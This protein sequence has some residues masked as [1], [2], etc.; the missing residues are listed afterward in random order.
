[1]NQ[2]LEFWTGEGGD[3]YTRRN[4]VLAT[5]LLRR[6][7][8]W[9]AI[10]DELSLEAAHIL[11]VGPGPGANL[12]VLHDLM[13]D[14]YLYGVEPNEAAR[15]LLAESC[16]FTKIQ[17]GHAANILAEDASFDLVFTAGVLIHIH[18]SRLQDAIKEIIR[19]SRRFVLAI[20]Y[21]APKCEPVV[22][23]GAERIWRNDFGKLYIELGLRHLAH[24]F[25]W[26]ETDGFDST[27]WWL[28]EKPA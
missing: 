21:F 4:D 23:Y 19:V 14:A 9:L 6:R 18:P 3:S 24:G 15:K 2:E 10:V 1:M 20:E 13:P 11:E 5:E 28:M 27:V 26:R 16:P 22:Y 17:D 7:R 25:F 12:H 8:S